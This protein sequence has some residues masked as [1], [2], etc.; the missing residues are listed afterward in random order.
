MANVSRRSFIKAVAAVGVATASL[1]L[2]STLYDAQSKDS[3]H[4]EFFNIGAIGPSS[5]VHSLYGVAARY[6]AQVAIDELNAKGIRKYKLNWQDTTSLTNDAPKCYQNLKEWGAQIILG[7]LL[8]EPAHAVAMR[9]QADDI[10]MLTPSASSRDVLGHQAIVKASDSR[11]YSNIFASCPADEVFG[12]KAADAIAK[13]NPKAKIGVIY[14]DSNPY[15]IGVVQSFLTKVKV[16]NLKLYSVSTFAGK[17]QNYSTAVED[18][19]KVGVDVLFIPLYADQAASILKLSSIKEYR[20][21]FVGADGLDGLIDLEGFDPKLSEGLYYLSTFDPHAQD[22]K[23][24]LFGEKYKQLVDGVYP[25]QCAA[26]AYDAVYIIDEL[27]KKTQVL[28]DD[29]QD[30]IAREL[31]NAIVSEDFAFTGL[32]GKQIHWFDDGTCDIEP[33]AYIIKDGA[34]EKL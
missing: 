26:Q 7:P 23:V 30:L 13:Y 16:L 17:T 15:S 31:R 25:D 6:G 20:P 21:A 1:R 10:F 33:A 14:D 24:K 4:D 9:A 27:L 32:T 5:G 19:K 29:P 34:E 8:S 12:E 28:P 2:T 11:R 3:Q 22:P 18:A